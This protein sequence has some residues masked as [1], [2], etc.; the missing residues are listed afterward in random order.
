MNNQCSGAAPICR[1]TS[2]TPKCYPCNVNGNFGNGTT[3]G[4]CPEGSNCHSDGSCGFCSTTPDIGHDGSKDNPHS[5]CTALNPKCADDLS[6]CECADDLVCN[7]ATST[8]CDTTCKCG[9]AECAGGTPICDQSDAA[10]PACVACSVKGSLGNG[11]SQGT[12]PDGSNCHSTGECLVCTEGVG[13]G[14]KDDPHS[15]CTALN[16]S[17]KDN[18]CQCADDLFCDM[19][20]ATVCDDIIGV[21]TCDATDCADDATM[22]ICDQTGTPTCARCNVD[23][24]DGDGTTQGNCP[25]DILKCQADGSCAEYAGNDMIYG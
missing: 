14:T 15:G 11:I 1:M 5:G 20:T 12:C 7:A 21:C 10:N 25:T 9:G 23:G 24:S 16:P 4:T 19:A 8:V 6:M 22:P 17:C 2:S 3:Q 13:A 18:K